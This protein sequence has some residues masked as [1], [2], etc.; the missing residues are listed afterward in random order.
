VL[1]VKLKNY[2]YRALWI[3]PFTSPIAYIVILIT[4]FT[5]LEIISFHVI[6]EIEV[7]PFAMK[8]LLPPVLVVF[9]ERQ[10]ISDTNL[11]SE[12]MSFVSPIVVVH[13]SNHVQNSTLIFSRYIPILGMAVKYMDS[14]QRICIQTKFNPILLYISHHNLRFRARHPSHTHCCRHLQH[15]KSSHTYISSLYMLQTST[16]IKP[17]SLCAS[18]SSSFFFFCAKI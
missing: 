5:I 2:A 16:Y 1:H 9:Q 4:N 18:S 11:V 17:S 7:S 3:H 15:K 13:L 6:P 10:S 12:P 14:P 8:Y